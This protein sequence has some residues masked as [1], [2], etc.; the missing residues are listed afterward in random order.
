M[1]KLIQSLFITGFAFYCNLSL[2]ELPAC[3]TEHY[4]GKS[5]T[6][7]S[8]I[9]DAPDIAENGAVVSIG[10]KDFISDVARRV[11]K[12]SFYNEFRKEPVASFILGENTRIAGL[13]TRMRL[14]ESSNIYAIAEL[15]N[16]ELISGESYVKV[17]I[18]GCG[19]GGMP[20]STGKATR[21][22]EK[23]T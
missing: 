3:I 21:V 12:V 19:G 16:G 14:R 8:L 7:N 23:K 2:A 9:L 11:K 4:A 18:E 20:R 15:D 6:Q 17:T 22:C 5:I 1:K 10:I 13:K